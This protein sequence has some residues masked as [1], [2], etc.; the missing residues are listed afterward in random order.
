MQFMPAQFLYSQKI[1]IE[2]MAAIEAGSPPA[3]TEGIF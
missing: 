1:H 3:H 2:T